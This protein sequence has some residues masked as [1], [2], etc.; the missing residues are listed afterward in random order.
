MTSLELRW[1]S[2]LTTTGSGKVKWMLYLP[3]AQVGDP[4]FRLKL[5]W[6]V[7]ITCIKLRCEIG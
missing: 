2:A 1:V 5:K 6:G 7:C 4:M 3:Q